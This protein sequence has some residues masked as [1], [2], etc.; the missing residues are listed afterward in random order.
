MHAKY[1]PSLIETKAML[2]K[3]LSLISGLFMWCFAAVNFLILHQPLLGVV[4]IVCGGFNLFCFYHVYRDSVKTW[5]SVALLLSIT[6]VIF[7]VFFFADLRAGSVFWLLFLPPLYCLLT[8]TKSALIY[9]IAFAIPAAVILFFKS[10]TDA[11]IAWRAVTNF[12]ITYFLSYL[13]CYLYQK[14]YLVRDLS[15]QKMAF[16]DPLTGARNRHALKLFFYDFNKAFTKQQQE[17]THLLIIDI[18]FFKRVNDAFGHDVGDAV[19][20]QMTELLHLYADS[21]VVYRI[22]GE[23]FLI[24]LKE[25]TAQQALNFAEAIRKHV[26]DAVFHS[27]E[28]EIKVT[29]S[30]GVAPLHR[31]Q[32]FRDFLRAADKNLYSAKHKGRNMVH[33]DDTSKAH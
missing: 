8:S 33:C 13:I 26:E 30:I 9:S 4:E 25:H 17:D 22:G 19:L 2:H 29:V 24:V 6:T 32:T 20:A 31:D 12:L 11:Y 27:K 10:D 21:D 5:H 3:W 7:C 14:Q 15:L 16:Q 1:T 18:D 28:Q 23:E